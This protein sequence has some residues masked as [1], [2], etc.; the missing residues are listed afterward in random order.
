MI[1]AKLLLL[2]SSILLVGCVQS[3]QE[4]NPDAPKTNDPHIDAFLQ[5]YAKPEFYQIS[6]TTGDETNQEYRIHFQAP[7]TY[8]TRTYQDGQ[9]VEFIYQGENIYMK[10]AQDQWLKLP[11]AK[12]DPARSYQSFDHEAIYQYFQ[13]QENTFTSKGQQ[14]CAAGMC[15]VYDISNQDQQTSSIFIDTNTNQISQIYLNDPAQTIL[16][17]TY[18]SLPITIPDEVVEI[19]IPENPSPEDITQLE[20]IYGN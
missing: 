7:D 11:I 9:Q 15:S 16:S 8:Y 12:S 10:S 13:N 6:V 3:V 17:F 4:S 20:Q 2:I 14:Q 19:T 18:Q 1:K 5:S